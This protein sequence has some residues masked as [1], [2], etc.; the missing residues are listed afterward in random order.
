[1]AILLISSAAYVIRCIW[2]LVCSFVVSAI[3]SGMWF[4][5]ISQ[6]VIC[7]SAFKCVISCDVHYIGFKVLELCKFSWCTLCV[8]CGIK[9]HNN[10]KKSYLEKYF[11]VDS[12]F[13][14]LTKWFF[15]ISQHRLALWGT[16][17]RSC[18]RHCA[19]CRKVAGPIPDGVTGIFHWHNPSSR[20]MALGL[21]QPLTEMS[22]RNI[23]WVVKAAGA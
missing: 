16:R 22:T 2:Y 10:I 20:T 18:L 1:M 21:T 15:W 14:K 23:S 9:I 19:A 11:W 3:V 17:W 7:M 6:K 4:C 12:M 13:I 5:C 8:I